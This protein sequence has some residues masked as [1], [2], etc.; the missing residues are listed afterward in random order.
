MK[1]IFSRKK[2]KKK[3]L[4]I[5]EIF[6]L[7]LFFSLSVFLLLFI[8]FT[9]DFPKPEKFTE[10][11]LVQSTKIYDRTGKILLYN[12]YGEEKRT[13]V[14]LEKTP[15]YLR[16]AV[17]TAED[18]NFYKHH[19]I[20][21]PATLKALIENLK[22]RKAIRGGS[23]ISQQLIRSSFLTREKTIK[24][25]IRE[26]ILTL[27]L[28]RRYSKDQILEFYLNQIP[29]GGNLYGV[30]SASQAY[31]HKS[32]DQIS[33]AEAVILA[34]LIKAPSYLSPY[35]PH[36]DKLLARKDY[37]LN[38][39]Y[40]LGYI[41]KDELEKA[42]NEQVKFYPPAATIKAPHFVIYVINNYLIPRY[43]EEFLKESGL[44]VYTTLDWNL[45][46]IAEESIKKYSKI[47]QEFKAYNT[48]L[49]AINPENGQILSMVGSK[50][51][52]G[53]PYPENC[54]PGVNCLFSPQ[55]NVVIRK[56]QPGSAFKPFAYATAFQKGYTPDTI[57]W[58]VPTNFGVWGAKPY[59][60]KNYDGKFRGP[61]TFRQ[62]LAQSLNIPSIKV[63]YL[64]GLE[65]TIKTAQKMGITTLD[66]S[67]NYYGLSLVLGGGE[68]KLLEITS[69]YGVFAT[70]GLRVF[71]TPILRIE[72]NQGNVL[73]EYQN[74]TPKRVLS[75]EIA[76]LINDILSD[77]QARAPMFGLR[78][79]LYFSD[80][81]VA[82]KTGTTQNYRDA[83]TIGYVPNL[84][85]GVWVGNNDNSPMSEKPAVLTAGPIWHQFMEKAFHYYPPKSFKKPK[86]IITSKPVLNGQLIKPY[87][88]LL[89]YVDRNN[90]QGPRPENPSKD[91]QYILWETALRSYLE[92]KSF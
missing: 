82:V 88:S 34:S 19:G 48:A 9:K 31:F 71:P 2:Q 66:K 86:P 35:G 74:P 26:F 61:V 33:L 51:Y 28:E 64:A 8:Y 84:V 13:V 60:P 4:F 68:V 42:K 56:R 70:E 83:W 25:K 63:L 52:F 45:Q 23:T 46:K 67:P 37:I 43:G 85:T 21:F 91:P 87:H 69:A 62:S 78:S 24:R 22:M 89:Y 44:K 47:N 12:L 54:L 59:I 10:R 36:K 15:L 72:D 32:V 79:P 49:I 29:L 53:E 27:E 75:S 73:E 1:I 20:D 38:R 17:I 3:I 14:P 55:D 5:I 40:E 16:Q 77:N 90:P 58:D 7:F 80:Y 30:E 76:R 92:K 39:M 18:A 81:Q 65:E 57:L 11:S 41:S 6:I 50:D